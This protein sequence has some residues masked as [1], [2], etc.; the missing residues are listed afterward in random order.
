MGLNAK[1]MDEVGE[2]VNMAFLTAFSNAPKQQHEKLLKFAF[3]LVK[4]EVPYTLFSGQLEGTQR[5]NALMY[6]DADIRDFVLKITMH[7]F[8]KFGDVKNRYEG[9]VENIAEAIGFIQPPQVSS[10]RDEATQPIE[11][12]PDEL[13]GLL[14][15]VDDV[16]EILRWNRWAVTMA[17]MMLYLMTPEDLGAL[18]EERKQREAKELLEQQRALALEARR[19][20]KSQ[21]PA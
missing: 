7:V 16:A 14:P 20:G 6:D 17:L 8:S 21:E 18:I 3:G 19:A 11:L 9:L 12:M 13:K 5:L 1:E 15:T 2:L 4:Q 10:R